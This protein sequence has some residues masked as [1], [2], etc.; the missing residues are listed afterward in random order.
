MYMYM[1]F[2]QD[3]NHLW[4]VQSVQGDP[5]RELFSRRTVESLLSQ[6]EARRGKIAT[7]AD[8]SPPHLQDLGV[9]E[10]GP[11]AKKPRL[12]L[13]EGMHKIN[14][15]CNEHMKHMGRPGYKG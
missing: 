6:L 2:V 4:V 3:H 1:L 11:A 7:A 15:C 14:F 9:G 10:G 8:F 5:L 12:A 13:D